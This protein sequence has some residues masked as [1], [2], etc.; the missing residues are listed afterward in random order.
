MGMRVAEN[1]CFYILTVFVLAYGEEELGLAKGTM[2][3]GV[4]IAAA[5]G[6]VTV[7]LWARCRTASAAS[8]STSPAR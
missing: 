7:P 2:L 6:L 4:I 1:G 3:W 5:I 8:P